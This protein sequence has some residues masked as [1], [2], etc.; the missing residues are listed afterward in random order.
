MTRDKNKK[1]YPTEVTVFESDYSPASL[2]S[3]FKGQDASVSTMASSS[4]SQQDDITGIAVEANVVHFLP[5][6]Y[7][8][9]TADADLV[10]KFILIAKTKPEVV[11]YL[12][13]KQDNTSWSAVIVGAFLDRSLSKPGAMGWNIPDRNA[14]IYDGGDQEYAAMNTLQIGRAVAAMLSPE[15]Q[16]VTAD[17][18]VYIDSFTLTQNKVS[19]VR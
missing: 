16:A 9:D 11:Q 6:T 8:I 4:D 2:K 13:S 3:I 10:N 1:S 18:Y 14:V 19:L 5:A 12:K 7:G 15:C 17:Q